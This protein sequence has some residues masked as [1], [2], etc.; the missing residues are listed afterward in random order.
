MIIGVP[1]E[2][3]DQEFRVGIVPAG[4]QAL[5]DEGHRV[6]V[7]HGA[8]EGSGF[9]DGEFS[10]A[11]AELTDRERL[12]GTS[13][14]IVKV[15]EPLPEEYRFFRRGLILFTFLHLAS[16]RDLTLGLMKGQVTA[17]GYETIEDKNGELPLL[18]PMSEVAGKL[19]VQAG[20]GYLQKDRGGAGILL[21]GV[22]GVRHGHVA[23]LGGGVVGTN[24]ARVALGLGSEVTIIDLDLRRLA[25]LDDIF[26]A[27]VE[28]LMSNRFNIEMAALRADLLIGAVLVPGAQSP[29][30]VSEEIVRR[31][32]PGSVIVDVAVDQGGCVET[33]RPST[34]SNPT[35]L[36]HGVIHYGVTNM[37]SL[38]PQTSTFALTNSTLP[39]LVKIARLGLEEAVREDPSLKKG[40]NVLAGR[41]VHPRVA[42]AH[43]LPC[44]PLP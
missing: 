41:L 37:P 38:V 28:T 4:V 24:A 1:Q 21:G 36:K 12:Y 34:H 35:Y 6:L 18:A 20:A 8:G 17:V 23:I 27:K 19:A 11:G 16:N 15:K 25:Y 3:M 44:H 5:K 40:L 43:H 39:Y 2:L 14:V 7:E 22:P 30:L 32:R 9:P 31:M 42:E 33:I 13:N 26:H 10:R 29:V